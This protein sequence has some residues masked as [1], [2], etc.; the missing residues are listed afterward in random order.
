MNMAFVENRGCRTE[1]EIRGPLYITILII[2]FGSR[3]AAKQ[4]VLIP[5]EAAM[6][7]GSQVSVFHYS[8]GLSRREPG[9]IFERYIFCTEV[10][11]V[12]KTTS[13]SPGVYGVPGWQA[14]SRMIAENQDHAIIATQMNVI[15]TYMQHL[16]VHPRFD[17]YLASRCGQGI[18]GRLH[19]A[20]VTAAVLRDGKRLATLRDGK[21]LATL[22]DEKNTDQKRDPE[23]Y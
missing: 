22:R 19:G 9:I 3:T 17:P 16:P 7:E 14:E 12:D 20:E 8:H 6:K 13:R 15:L 4:Y 18:Q 11:S 5:D 1:Y 10:V 21:R 23:H 2:L